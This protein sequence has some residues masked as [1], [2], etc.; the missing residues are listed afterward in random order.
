MKFNR[1]AE[2]LIA[3]LRKVPHRK[4]PAVIRDILPLDNVVEVLFER[5]KIGKESVE[6]TIMRRWRD[7]VGS[8]AAHRCR[9]H[10]IVDGKRLVIITTNAVLRQEL[11]FRKRD[12]LRQLREIPDCACLQDIVFRAG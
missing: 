5:Y 10:K 2:S 7:I 1:Q 8:E 11:A 4:S 9:P 12:I 3:D 6:D